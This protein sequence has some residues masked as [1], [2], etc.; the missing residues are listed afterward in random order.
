MSSPQPS[1]IPLT[2]HRLFTVTPDDHRGQVWTVSLIFGIFS[3][4]VLCLRGF[5]GQGNLGRDDCSAAA[6]TV[7]CMCT[8][9][10]SVCLLTHVKLLGLGQLGSIL[11][12]TSYGLGQ[13]DGGTFRA[14]A[15][16][17]S[18]AGPPFNLVSAVLNRCALC[19]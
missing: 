19:S 9:I 3:V 17:V 15:G 14:K 7:S 10:L 1:L 6:A 11:A 4:L 18:F 13:N 2:G 12:A 16:G 5:V 8:E